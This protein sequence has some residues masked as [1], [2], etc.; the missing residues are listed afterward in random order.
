M[1]KVRFGIIGCGTISA[2]HAKG[3]SN[4]PEAELV[5]C[6]DIVEEKAKKLAD[7]YGVSKIY[8]DYHELLASDE[9]DAVNVC[10]PS[11]LHGQITI[12]AAK[13]GKHVLCE[14]P[15]EITLPK[16]DAMIKAC[17]EAN[18]KFGVIFQRRT[19][20]MWSKIKKAV[21]SG[22][23]GKMVLGDAYLKYLR[24]Q[25]YYDSG[26][27]R[28]TWA[29]DGGGALM[30]QGVHMID[31][32]RWIMGPIDTIYAKADHLVRNIEVEDTACAVIQYK[33]GAFGVLEG[34]TSVYP[35][36]DHRMELHGEKGT[37]LVDGEKIAKWDIPEEET[38]ECH[39][40]GNGGVDIKI[41]TAATNPT[42]IATEGHQ[43]QIQD[44]CHAITE[45]RNPMITGEEARNAVEVI[46]AI[47]ES[48]R[49]GLPV[50]LPLKS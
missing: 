41:G 40:D 13:A 24:T 42:S 31:L 34:T 35:G 7:E 44:L 23:L 28:G 27:W 22:C 25:A 45:D 48:A 26:D 49:T 3:I 43:I 36:M 2:W 9:V 50:K 8:T 38:E 16:I 47:Y 14:K 20:P 21:D 19:S 29:L 37:I 46:L 33:S 11:G 6:C 12:D 30:N 5:A 39:I 4:T 1:N 10:T 18:I 15:V 17:H 32:L